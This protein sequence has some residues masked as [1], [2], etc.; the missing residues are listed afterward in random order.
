MQFVPPGA[1]PRRGR[2]SGTEPDVRFGFEHPQHAA[3][4]MHR[5]S[6][7]LHGLSIRKTFWMARHAATPRD[8]GAMNSGPTGSVMVSR[9]IR[10]ISALAEASS[11]HPVTSSTGCN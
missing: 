5:R 6:A 2:D 1:Q 9:R 10:L 3:E 7:R 4:L 8:G 11:D